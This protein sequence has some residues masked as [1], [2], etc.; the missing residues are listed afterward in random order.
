MAEHD[1]EFGDGGRSKSKTTDAPTKKRKHKDEK[2]KTGKHPHDKD[3]IEHA[4]LQLMIAADSGDTDAVKK[5]LDA[6]IAG[7]HG[8]MQENHGEF[9]AGSTALHYAARSGHVGAVVEL[10]LHGADPCA[11]NSG[12]WTPLHFAANSGHINVIKELLRAPGASRALDMKED[13]YNRTPWDMAKLREF[14]DAALLLHSPYLHLIA[15]L[16][17]ATEIK[18]IPNARKAITYGTMLYRRY[19]LTDKASVDK[20]LEFRT[21]RLKNVMLDAKDTLLG[22]VQVFVTRD[23]YCYQQ[24]IEQMLMQN[25]RIYRTS[26]M[27]EVK[28]RFP[29]CFDEHIIVVKKD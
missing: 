21:S 17:R 28:L 1:T 7:A 24:T 9:N 22:S 4:P 12:G 20:F 3:R 8:V 23:R 26:T 29:L 11:T 19:E 13:W 15:N 6:K 2:K 25:K 10:L 14:E 16:D 18:H 5:M 27:G